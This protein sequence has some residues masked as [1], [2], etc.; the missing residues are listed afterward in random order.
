VKK[1]SALYR[2]NYTIPST[3]L[4]WLAV[5]LF[6]ASGVGFAYYRMKR[7][8]RIRIDQ[9]FAEVRQYVEKHYFD[10]YTYSRDYTTRSYHFPDDFYLPAQFKNDGFVFSVWDTSAQFSSYELC[11]YTDCREYRLADSLEKPDYVSVVSMDTICG[12]HYDFVTTLHDFKK[13]DLPTQTIRDT[14]DL[15]YSYADAKIFGPDNNCEAADI[16]KL[17]PG[18]QYA[19]YLEGTDK[20]TN[21]HPVAFKIQP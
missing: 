20:N 16:S 4:I 6:V 1:V 13:I 14:N 11:L 2:K 8:D 5:L 3:I 18:G 12:I 19:A 21:T 17:G 9:K 15:V 7:H 10:S